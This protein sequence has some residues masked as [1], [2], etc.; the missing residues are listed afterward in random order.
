[1]VLAKQGGLPPLTLHIHPGLD[2]PVGDVL[3]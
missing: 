1:M 2:L 3:H